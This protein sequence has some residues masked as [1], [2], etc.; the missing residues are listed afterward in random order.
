MQQ[1]GEIL[2]GRPFGPE[3]PISPQIA[4]G[5]AVLNA[6]VF[7][8]YL[9]TTDHEISN[10]IFLANSFL[11]DRGLPESVTPVDIFLA[12]GTVASELSLANRE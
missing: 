4:A 7:D 12:K 3:P 1:T 6:F 8:G 11:R 5:A 9:P 2:I 10:A